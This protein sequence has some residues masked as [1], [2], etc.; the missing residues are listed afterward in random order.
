[1]A[2][3]VEKRVVRATLE[4]IQPIKGGRGNVRVSARAYPGGYV[5]SD[6]AGLAIGRRGCLGL[7]CT[8]MLNH[9]FAPTTKRVNAMIAFRSVSS[10][11][12][13]AAAIQLDYGVYLVI[14]C[15]PLKKTMLISWVSK[16]LQTQLDFLRFFRCR[17]DDVVDWDAHA[18]P[19]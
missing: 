6:N 2:G 7:T 18:L 12:R 15:L 14:L 5:G 17:S 10:Q 9:C 8:A 16:C 19:E 4:H 1:M 11:I 13:Y 3:V